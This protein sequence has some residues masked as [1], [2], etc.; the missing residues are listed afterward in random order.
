MPFDRTRQV[1]SPT[2]AVGDGPLGPIPG[3]PQRPP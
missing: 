2:A 1:C 3:S